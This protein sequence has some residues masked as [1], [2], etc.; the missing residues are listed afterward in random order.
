MNEI[1]NQCCTFY[2]HQIRIS[3]W[4]W[5]WQRLN[6][7]HGLWLLYQTFA[8]R[9][10]LTAIH[11]ASEWTEGI[12]FNILCFRWDYVHHYK[13]IIQLKQFTRRFP[14]WTLCQPMP[15]EENWIRTLTYIVSIIGRT[16]LLTQPPV[17]QSYRNKIKK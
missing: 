5:F 15:C 8:V 7:G 6:S 11:F 10:Q 1:C 2:I 9:S 12:I 17:I 3:V 4:L 16:K 13:I 14:S